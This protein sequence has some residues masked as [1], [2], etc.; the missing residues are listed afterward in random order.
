MAMKFRKKPG[1][2]WQRGPGAKIGSAMDVASELARI[3]GR[4]VVI[5]VFVLVVVRLSG[6]RTVGN[7]SALD[8]IVALIIGEV[9]DEPILGD[10]PIVQGL[11]AISTVAALHFVNSWLGYRSPQY[12]HLTSGSPQV[13]VRNGRIDRAA[14]AAERINE[15]ELRALL[16]LEHIEDLHDVKIATLETTGHLSVIKTDEATEAQ[17]RDLKPPSKKGS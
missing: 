4:T 10:V 16:R 11:V 17:R 2:V 15:E 3:A 14:S 6:K 8:L 5:Y 12:E 9:V 7:F 1:D 13:L